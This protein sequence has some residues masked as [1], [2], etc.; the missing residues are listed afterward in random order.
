MGWAMRKTLHAE[1][2]IAA[3]RMAVQRQRPEPGLI[4][5][6]DC[7]A[8]YACEAFRAEFEN[9]D[10]VAS[11]SPKSDCLDITATVSVWRTLKNRARL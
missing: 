8:Q 3:C 9:A 7:G 10:A 1:L 2:V 6:S 11:M 4:H 5:H